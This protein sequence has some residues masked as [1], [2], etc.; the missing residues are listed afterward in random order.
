MKKIFIIALLSLGFASLT[1]AQITILAARGMALGSVVTVS[2]TV[3][4]GSELGVIRYMQDNTAGIAAYCSSAQAATVVRGDIITVTGT[5]KNYNQLLEIDPVASV[6]IVSHGNTLPDPVLLTP[7]QIS[8]SYESKLL[9][10][11]DAVLKDAGLIFTGNK[12]YEF[13]AKG[14]TGF[15]FVKTGQAIVGTVIP[16]GTVNITAICS[17]FDYTSPTA[18]YQLLPRDLNDLHMTSSI[19][20]TNS[21]SNTAFT[22]TAMDFT[23]NTNIAGTTQMF[24]GPT[25]QTFKTNVANGTGGT[26]SHSIS[27]SGLVAGE[28]VWVEAFSVT[29]NDTAK[30]SVRPYAT[31]SNSSGAMKAYFNTPVDVTVSKG[32]DAIYL[33]LTIDDTL[34]KYINRAQ[35]TI[36]FTIYNFNNQGISNISNALK[37]AAD[38]GVR[39]RVIGCGTT[40]NLGIDELANSAVNI[41]IGPDN[42]HRAG[43][44]HNK[45]IV[46][47][48]Q[49]TNPN[50]PLVWTGSTN[51]TD[52]QINLDANNVVIIQDQSLARSYQIEFEE[53]WGS[54]GAIA[55]ATKAHFGSTK[56]N[57]TPHEFVI[58]GKRVES[59]FS[60]T[61]GV[62]ARIVQVINTADK[63]LSIATMLITR[64]EM[65]DAIATRKTA[66]VA[67]NVI[68]NAFG[69][70]SSVVNPILSNS[71]GTH[72]TSDEVSAG[73][74]H[75][76][77]MVV[78][79]NAPASDPMVLTGS[80]NWSAA[81]DNENDEN[82]L[83]IHDATIANIYYQNFAQRFVENLGVLF[84]LTIAPT[85][86]NDFAN[87]LRSESIAVMV[88][89]N[90]AMLAPVTLSIERASTQGSSE[91]PFSPTN[92]IKYTPNT[93]FAGK[94]SVS[95]RIAY[96]AKPTLFSIAK[97]YF[98]VAG[99]VE[100]DK[101]TAQNSLNVSPNPVK[102]GIIHLS[103]SIPSDQ[104]GM[105]QITDMTGK[106]VFTSPVS[107]KAGDNT[108]NYALPRLNAGIY[109]FR[110]TTPY[111]TWSKKIIFE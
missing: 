44:M 39:V 8:E 47:D 45:F 93:G 108:L 13:T 50:V 66:G 77:Y 74:L 49:S 65:A 84:E 68:T 106:T 101:I 97:I 6:V 24:Y 105:M 30:S 58:D 28:I 59:Y 38:R 61:D 21:M 100:V 67:V 89:D 2:G 83:V 25:P 109:S 82:T 75:H 81:A 60:P 1:N 32:V 110:L 34:I 43:I 71:L 20:L 40:A 78:D 33:P 57:N 56:K 54:T 52:G 51:F 91:L 41:L 10:I 62:N 35:Q 96:T 42:T 31:I 86:V 64:T 85:A 46:F 3:T 55:D 111:K 5:L 87:T 95:Y 17:Q 107:L 94:D 88:L 22:K 7:A 73:I 29:G 69:N 98:T 90:D 12:K 79:Q 26:T 72:N 99:Y 16:S 63:D 27:L 4:N 48:A 103:V 15:F 9:K 36:D 18:G 14:E 11:N 76:K 102:D 23:W 92:A 80:H 104:T 37:A 19:F 53:M 70:N